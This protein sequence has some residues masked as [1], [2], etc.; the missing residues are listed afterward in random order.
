MPSSSI[1][2]DHHDVIAGQ[3]TLGLELMDELP[4]LD[5]IVLGIGGGGLIAGVAAAVKARAAAEGRTVRVIGV[6]AANSAAYPPSLEAGHPLEV[7]TLP[8]DRRRHRRG[9]AG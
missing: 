1:P 2:F 3:G 9:P 7:P 5:T 4:D 8:Y 6:Q